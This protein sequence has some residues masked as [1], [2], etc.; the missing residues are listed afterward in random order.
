MNQSTRPIRIAI[1]RQKYDPHGGA[2]RFVQTML[3]ALQNELAEVEL[4]LITRNW[5]IDK[6][7]KIRIIKCNP[8]F[9]GRI[10][11]DWSFYRSAC[12]IISRHQFDVVQSHERI[13]CA[14]IYRAG[15]GVH[16]EWLNQRNRIQ[17]SIGK[18][19][20]K[21]SP[22]HRYILRQEQRV[23][24]SKALLG[25]IANSEI[26]RQEIIRNFP[27]HRAQI[28][29]IPNSVDSEKFYVKPNHK[30]RTRILKDLNIPEDSFV[31]I[32]VGSGYER[33]GVSALINVF[34]E[35][36]K[37]HHLIIIGRDKNL[38][39][40]ISRSEEYGLA[41]RLH[42]IGPQE[43]VRPFFNA[44]DLFVFPSLYD[45]LPN[46]ALEAAASGLPVLASKT[47]GAAD[48][49]NSMGFAALDPL[50]T[51]SW[52][53]SIEEIAKTN[54]RHPIDISKYTSQT[55]VNSLI[56]LY[57]NILARKSS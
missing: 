15:E 37:E 41:K 32:F 31:C 46:S 50:D 24:E 23:F 27:N 39:R 49:T 14:D 13:L 9:I 20:N 5:K 16:R 36:P 45:P 6:A 7:S 22:Y 38:K 43:D 55:M 25:I 18:L 52:K 28:H 29:V 17:S 10:W 54:P 57:K 26:T 8:F 56:R 53:K 1:V 48:L 4:T 51:P 34:R 12:R 40:F 11:R 21:F 3:H 19:W 33:K 35:L 2:E 30:D 47:T 42:F 44:S